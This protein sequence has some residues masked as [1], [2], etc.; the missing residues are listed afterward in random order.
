MTQTKKLTLEHLNKIIDQVEVLKELCEDV[1]V[2][3]SNLLTI[4]Y[5]SNEKDFY[6]IAKELGVEWTEKKLPEEFLADRE[7]SFQ[8]RG[9]DVTIFLPMKE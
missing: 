8:Y 1:V 3:P 6:S 9:Y 2:P 4:Y 5:C 7:R